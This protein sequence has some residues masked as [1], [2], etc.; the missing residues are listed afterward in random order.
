VRHRTSVIAII[1]TG[2]ALLLGV[3]CFGGQVVAGA[4]T[5]A[6]SADH[7]ALIPTHS[8]ATLPRHGGTVDSL[9]WSGYAVTPSKDGI[10]AVKSTFVVPT[11]GSVPPGFAATWTGIGGYTSSDLI[12]A[13]VSENSTP[14][15]SV[16]GD[17]YGAWYE[18]LPASETALTKCT[19]KSSCPV[20]PGDKVTVSIVKAGTKK[21]TI[22]LADPTEH[23][24]WTKTVTYT[25]TE[26]SAEW[27]LEAPTVGAQTVLADVGTVKFGPTS[28]YVANG[29]TYTI[30]KGS[31][32]KIDL[33]PGGG[34]NEATP[35]ALASNGESFNDCAYAQT[36]AAP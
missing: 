9:N 22:S 15:N 17:Q 27:I 23:W 32:T 25:S 1:G 30:A 11:A 34:V 29:H 28:T 26:S 8:G 4:P 18:L 7:G 35:S 5:A 10:T 16:A 33:S 20:S 36:C 21:W 24:T 14:N 6:A 19:G 12:Q 2:I 31:P 13:G 3:L